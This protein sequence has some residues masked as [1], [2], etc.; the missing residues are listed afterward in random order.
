MENT[1]KRFGK[2]PKCGTVNESTAKEC[3]GCGVIF[4]KIKTRPNAT[5]IEQEKPIGEKT[6]GKVKCSNCG[7]LFAPHAEFCPYCEGK[8]IKKQNEE[9]PNEINANKLAIVIAAVFIVVI[10][11][12]FN[13]GS[14]KKK[15]D[16]KTKD[17]SNMAYVMMGNFVEQRLKSPKSADF[18]GGYYDKHTTY[19]GNQKYRIVSYVDAENSFGVDIRTHFVG[20]IKQTSEDEWQ[21]LS[22][23]F[24]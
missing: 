17:N 1:K 9:N 8:P 15:S 19:L 12:A 5:E 4:K 20:E 6:D 18:P 24:K 11:M 23:N 2:C 13:S 16:W 7:K 10:F 14:E 3:V 21:L 22:L